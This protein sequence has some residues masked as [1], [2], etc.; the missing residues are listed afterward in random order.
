MAFASLL[1]SY[2]Y[3]PWPFGDVRMSSMLIHGDP[4]FMR[5]LGTGFTWF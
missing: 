2:A 5:L 3:D 4:I 1:V